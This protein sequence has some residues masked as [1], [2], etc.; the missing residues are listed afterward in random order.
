M[1]EIAWVRARQHEWEH[2]VLLLCSPLGKVSNKAN[3]AGGSTDN[4]DDAAMPDPETMLLT[5]E[6][7]SAQLQEHTKL[8]KEQVITEYSNLMILL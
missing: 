2:F 4:T 3:E 7:V 6:A 1:E 5:V 8:C